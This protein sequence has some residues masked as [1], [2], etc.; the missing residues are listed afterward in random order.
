[1]AQEVLENHLFIENPGYYNGEGLEKNHDIV[2]DKLVDF[3]D[4]VRNSKALQA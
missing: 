2:E 4:F 3:K 1:M